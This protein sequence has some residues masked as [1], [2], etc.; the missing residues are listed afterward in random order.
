MAIYARDDFACLNCGEHEQEDQA[1]LSL[2][3]VSD[4][5]GH[6]PTNLI[7]LC[8]SCNSGRGEREIEEF[9]PELARVARIQTA[10][11]LDRALGR[12]LAKQRWPKY[13]EACERRERERNKKKRTA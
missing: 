8:V 13:F 10:K 7:T 1:H 5:G 12:S 11:P 4:D 9:N 3:H 2:D 6:G